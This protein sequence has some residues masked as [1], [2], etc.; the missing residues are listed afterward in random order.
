MEAV[1]PDEGELKGRDQIVA[2]MRPFIDAFPG[3]SFE[4]IAAYESGDVAIDEGYFVGTNTAPLTLPGGQTLPPT[5]KSV[6]V[7]SCDVATVKNGLI[8][9]Y[10]LYFDQMDLLTQLGIAP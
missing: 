4:P 9:H 6:R 2:P 7:R 3:A 1:V 8:T 10:R 5:G